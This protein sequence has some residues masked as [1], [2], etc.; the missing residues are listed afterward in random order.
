MT[1]RME[2]WL[3]LLTVVLGR[4]IE[5]IAAMVIAVGAVRALTAYALSLVRP[6]GEAIPPSAIRLALG[7]TRMSPLPTIALAID[8]AGSAVVAV[9]AARAVGLFFATLGRP[10]RMSEQQRL[11]ASGLVLALTFKSGAGMLRTATVQTWSQL[12]LVTAIIAIRFALGRVLSRSAS[13]VGG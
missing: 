5:G 12:G 13:G 11:L 9:A 10:E 4:V 3:K 6:T 1:A 7:R 8:T 2:E